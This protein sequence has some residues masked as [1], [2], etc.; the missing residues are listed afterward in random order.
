MQAATPNFQ[1]KNLCPYFFC[2]FVL[3]REHNCLFAPC[4]VKNTH[5]F[6]AKQEMTQTQ[7]FSSHV[8]PSINI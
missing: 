5:S 6:H 4:K 3:G 7:N 2:I 8:H 1:F